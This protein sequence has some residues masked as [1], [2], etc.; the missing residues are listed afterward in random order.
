MLDILFL[1]F[2]LNIVLSLFAELNIQHASLEQSENLWRH[3]TE[4]F[5][6]SKAL[7]VRRGAPFRVSLQ[8]EGRPFNPKSDSLGIRL[9]LGTHRPPPPSFY[10]QVPWIFLCLIVVP[11]FRTPVHV[12]A[13]HLLQ[14]GVLHPLASLLRTAGPG[15]PQTLHIHLLS[16]LGLSGLLQI[17]A[18]YLHTEQEEKMHDWEI[19]PP[20]QSLV[21]R[22]VL[23]HCRAGILSH[24]CVENIYVLN[25]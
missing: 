21:S 2:I 25:V 12:T 24:A 16:S 17:W 23:A 10:L 9:W 6:S 14:E 11:C 7:V 1:F 18:V 4:G 13:G 8:L 5:S 15:P 19:C 3:K 20:L 22:W